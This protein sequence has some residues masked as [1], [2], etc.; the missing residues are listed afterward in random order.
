[1][2]AV[3]FWRCI[4]MGFDLTAEILFQTVSFTFE[5]PWAGFFSSMVMVS[6]ALFIES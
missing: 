1:M 4:A 6:T 5:M 2:V 3:L